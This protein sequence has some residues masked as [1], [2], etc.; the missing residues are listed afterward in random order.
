MSAFL[1]LNFRES[2]CPICAGGGQEF[3]SRKAP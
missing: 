2:I 1:S 3:V